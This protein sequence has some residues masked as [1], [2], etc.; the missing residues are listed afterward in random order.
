LFL[1]IY[2][3]KR[4]EYL[5]YRERLS[6]GILKLDESYELVEKMQQDLVE[7]SPELERKTKVRLG[8]VISGLWERSLKLLQNLSGNISEHSKI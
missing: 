6:T 5:T 8:L 3:E 1:K 7:L 2:A 4:Q